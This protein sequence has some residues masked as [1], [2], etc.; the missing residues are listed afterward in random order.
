VAYLTLPLEALEQR[1]TNLPSRGV[2]MTPGQDLNH[3]YEE[4]DPLYRKYAD[5]QVD[6]SGLNHEQVV[7]AIL[8]KLNINAEM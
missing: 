5:V 3:L 1:L 2:V 4:R 6:C 7:E 8:K